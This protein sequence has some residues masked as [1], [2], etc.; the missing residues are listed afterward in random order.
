MS[1]KCPAHERMFV[2]LITQNIPRREFAARRRGVAH[3]RGHG[4][5]GSR[6]G[7]GQRARIPACGIP[8][9]RVR[10]GARRPHESARDPRPQARGDGLVPSRHAGDGQPGATSPRCAGL[11]SQN[12]KNKLVYVRQHAAQWT[13]R[14]NNGCLRKGNPMKTVQ[15]LA[16][17][18]VAV[19]MMLGMVGSATR[20]A[21]TRNRRRV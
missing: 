7:Q 6:G 9:Y 12:S 19:A 1:Q 14:G 13:P 21:K 16:V 3:D 20:S 11:S 5:L 17:S 18:T 10:P 2:Q 4:G 8:G 15:R